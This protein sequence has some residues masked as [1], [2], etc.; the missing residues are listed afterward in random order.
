MERVLHTPRIPRNLGS[1][2]AI[3]LL[4]LTAGCTSIPKQLIGT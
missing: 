4:L 3:G 1:L 2:V